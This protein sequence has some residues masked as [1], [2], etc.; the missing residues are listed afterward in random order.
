M[1]IT[2]YGWAGV[3]LL[4]QLDLGGHWDYVTFKTW[5]LLG[6]WLACFTLSF[7]LVLQHLRVRP[8]P[9]LLAPPDRWWNFWTLTLAAI[10]AV[11]ALLVMYDFSIL[12]GYGFGAGAA[13]IRAEE[14]DALL[15]GAA[16]GGSVVSGLGRLMIPAAFVATMLLTMRWSL[17]TNV[18]RL[19]VVTSLTII[20]GEQVLFEGGRFFLTATILTAILCYFMFPGLHDGLGRAAR[21]KRIPYI[22]IGLAMV[23]LMSFFT[24]VFVDRI[25]QRGDFFWSAYQTFASNYAIDVDYETVSRFEGVFGPLWFSVSMLWLYATQGINELDLLLSMQY[26]NHA[27][28]LYQVPHIGQIAQVV[29]GVDIRYDLIA[30]LPTVGTYAT[31]YGSNFID[32]GN[33]G[34]MISALLLGSLTARGVTGFALGRLDALSLIGPILL[35][36]CLF[37]PVISILTNLWPAMVWAVVV[38]IN[39]RK[40][41]RSARAPRV[42]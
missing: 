22:R 30:N 9:E 37:S 20:I 13:A 17:L 31:F 8:L 25:L 10:G 11:G 2:L 39:A 16:Q 3:V 18:T 24:Y 41:Q 32:F 36:L 34:A 4:H 26:F 6:G 29:F 42:G 12:R 19:V 38:G 33:V 7:W 27:H 40:W 21:K 14:T 5:A 28:G 35:A 15:R 23:V 1:L